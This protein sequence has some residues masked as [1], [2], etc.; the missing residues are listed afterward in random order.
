M[1]CLHCSG[2]DSTRLTVQV[3]HT[4]NKKSPRGAGFK[5]YFVLDQ[6]VTVRA[7]GPGW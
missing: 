5:S 6:T 2:Q 7:W 3:G 1:Y 4:M